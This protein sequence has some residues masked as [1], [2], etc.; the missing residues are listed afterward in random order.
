MGNTVHD[1]VGKVKNQMSELEFLPTPRSPSLRRRP[2]AVQRNV[3]G[4]LKALLD[5][6]LIAPGG[7]RTGRIGEYN[8]DQSPTWVAL[9]RTAS[10]T[11]GEGFHPAS[12]RA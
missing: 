3:S 8:R 6:A 5:P 7:V 2:R 1:M 11:I 12:R 10:M 4:V 9:L